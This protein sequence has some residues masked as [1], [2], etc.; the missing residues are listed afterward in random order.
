MVN[1]KFNLRD[2]MKAFG[3]KDFFA[4]S[5]SFV[6][7]NFFRDEKR[8]KITRLIIFF[9]I[10]TIIISYFAIGWGTTKAAPL[11]IGVS[12]IKEGYSEF[13]KI[14]NI[15]GTGISLQKGDLGSWTNDDQAPIDVPDNMYSPEMVY[16][17]SNTIYM[18]T[19]NSSGHFVRYWVE[20]RRW[21]EL[22][23]LPFAN[24]SK[25]TFD[26]SRYFYAIA[27][28]GYNFF[29]YDSYQNVWD[30]MPDPPEELFGGSNIEY[31]GGASSY[32]YAIR[33]GSSG[34]FWRYS[35]GTA[36]WEALTPPAYA[37]TNG[38]AL[39]WDRGDFLYAIRGNYYYNLL[40]YQL[41]TGT[42]VSRGS[43][44][45][46]IYDISRTKMIFLNTNEFYV[47]TYYGWS[48]GKMSKYS[49][50]SNTFSDVNLPMKTYQESMSGVF[51]GTS[52]FYASI[53]GY[54]VNTAQI[55]VMDTG[56]NIWDLGQTNTTTPT[57]Y[58]AWAFDGADNLYAITGYYPIVTYRRNLATGV[59]TYLNP[60]PSGLP[61]A[62]HPTAAYSGGKIYITRGSGYQNFY[63]YDAVANLWQETE[64]AQTPAYVCT[65]S[66]LVDGGDGFLYLSRGCATGTFYRYNISGNTWSTINAI[67]FGMDLGG[68]IAKVGN[69]IYAFSGGDY[70]NNRIAKFDLAAQTWTEENAGAIPIG[71]PY[72]PRI[73]SDGTTNIYILSGPNGTETSSQRRFYQ[74]NTTT[75]AWKRLGDLPDYAR[76][77]SNP[78][79]F[80]RGTD[81][82]AN[83]GTYDTRLWKWSPSAAAFQT[84]GAWY[85]KHYDLTQ[86][87][88]FDQL[89]FDEVG[90]GTATV[91]TRSSSN[92]AAWENWTELSGH[93]VVSNAH[94]YFQF[95][96]VL[97]GDGTATPTLSNFSLSY[98][99]E[100]TPPS[101][102]ST[103]HAYDTSEKQQQLTTGV[104]YPYHHPYFEWSGADD[105]L[106]GS[107]VAGYY[108]YFGTD[109]N[110]DP[111]TA[112]NYQTETLYTAD[113]P[114]TAGDIDYFKIKVKDKLGNISD[115]GPPLFSYRY[116]FISPPGNVTVASNAEFN[117]GTGQGLD[118]T[119]PGGQATLIARPN[120]TWVNS[121]LAKIPQLF[122]GGAATY[123]HD[124]L[125]V[126]T[127]NGTKY[128]YRYDLNANQWVSLADTLVTIPNSYSGSILSYDGDDTI[129]FIAGNLSSSFAKYSISRNVWTNLG[130]L[131][132]PA[133]AE[134]A[135]APISNNKFIV[136]LGSTTFNY[137]YDSQK[138]SFEENVPC[139]GNFT[140]ASN[141]YFDGVDTVYV[142][143]QYNWL[144]KFVISENRWY[145][146]LQAPFY[147]VDN[148]NVAFDGI[149]DDLYFFGMRNAY[150]HFAA[151]Y[152][153]SENRFYEI[154]PP[155]YE[156][157]TTSYVVSDRNR[158]FF[159]FQ[160]AY[161]SSRQ[162]NIFFR[163]DTTNNSYSPNLY[164]PLRAGFFNR[165]TSWYSFGVED[166]FPFYLSDWGSATYDGTDRVY[167]KA[168][169]HLLEYSVSQKKLIRSTRMVYANY[170]SIFYLNGYVYNI[171]SNGTKRFFRY[172]VSTL[173]WEE[174]A[175]APGNVSLYYSENLFADK[176]GRL[177]AA[178]GAGS[179]TIYRYTPGANTW[180][181]LNL[182]PIAIN[183]G[184]TFAYD[185]NHTVY[186]SFSA[187]SSAYYSFDTD[188]GTWSAPLAVINDIKPNYGSYATYRQGKIYMM[189]GANTKKMSIYDIGAN[190]WSAGPDA[191]TEVYRGASF[192][193]INDDYG[194]LAPNGAKAAIWRFNFPSNTHG[195]SAVGVYTS[196]NFLIDGVFS[197]VG[198]EATIDT[199]ANT[200]VEFKTR[201][202]EDG[203]TWSDWQTTTET[204][205]VSNKVYGHIVSP[206]HKNIQVRA[207]LE[208]SDN[209]NRPII[210][211]FKVNYYADTTPPNNPTMVFIYSDSQKTPPALTQ[212]VWYKYDHPLIDWP[213]PGEAGGATDGLIG[214]NIAGYWVYFGFD[215]QAIPETAGQ[216]VTAT[217]YAPTLI[218]PGLY[219]LRIQAVD[220]SGNVAAEVYDAFLY[221]FDNEKPA[222]PAVISVDPSGYTTNNVFTFSWPAANDDYSGIKEYC[223]KTAATS[224]PYQNEQCQ[225]ANQIDSI[226]AA[227]QNG[228]NVIYVRSKDWAE[229]FSESSTQA[230]FYWKDKNLPENLLVTNL[231]YIVNG[232]NQFTF[233]WDV[234]LVYV[235]NVD[236]MSYYFSIN[237]LPS[238]NNTTRVEG[239][240][241]GPFA[242]ATQT[243]TNTFYI[244]ARDEASSLNDINWNNYATIDFSSNLVA[245]GIPVSLVA[246]DVSNRSINR[247]A[248]ALTWGAPSNP[249]SGVDHYVVDRSSD[250]LHYS[251]I[252]TPEDVS[253]VDNTVLENGLYYYRVRASSAVG[254]LGG[255]SSVVQITPIGKYTSAPNVT[256]GPDVTVGVN[257]A[258]I[259]W[260]TDRAAAGYVYYGSDM[261]TLIDSSGS[262][263]PETN[264]SV[265]IRG[266]N[267]NSVYYYQIQNFD[268]GR[269]YSL[270]QAL[271]TIRTFRTK[272][273]AVIQDVTVSEVKL[274][275]AKISWTTPS[276]TTFKLQYGKTTSYGLNKT[277]NAT[278]ETQS[279]E[280][281]DLENT[282]SYHFKITSTT[283]DG[284]EI[285]SDDYQ[286]S[287]LAY[288]V[289]TDIKFQPVE[290]SSNSVEVTW[291][292]NVK[293]TSIV[294]YQLGGTIKEEQAPASG[295][296]L[297][298]SVTLTKLADSAD[299]LV[300]VKGVDEYGNNA[301]GATQHWKTGV[302]TRQPKVSNIKTESILSAD[303]SRAQIVVSWETDEPTTSEVEYGLNKKYDSKS[304]KDTNL[305]NRHV[306]VI[307]NLKV[308]QIYHVRPNSEDKSG[309]KNFGE[310]NIVVIG[311]KDTN[312]IQIVL[313]FIRNVFGWIKIGR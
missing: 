58:T 229:N 135:M 242:A 45:P 269:E 203:V 277:G 183:D 302:D 309:N 69:Y 184:Y 16:G 148:Q 233:T 155:P 306:V 208:S 163:Y 303:E 301:I 227:Y 248:V 64:L 109:S 133:G 159:I 75:K 157:N 34:Y 210:Y 252:G 151:R 110:A 182:A 176:E 153:I 225:V 188:N 220:A 62:S 102:P 77:T 87:S 89:S 78:Y 127:G 251:Q 219:Y 200:S 195:N 85:S 112:G 44:Y 308:A 185:G 29:R 285:S 190:T 32:I 241:V 191:P 226:S 80:V 116:W 164:T 41:S 43:F 88:D 228:A 146:L 174:L 47:M 42:W 145:T 40:R 143:T 275:S 310:D 76:G 194:L 197:W 237:A 259:T 9:L 206:I 22:A 216:Y 117:E 231:D 198:V 3:Q 30:K 217:E 253:F 13:N 70:G 48:S 239:L 223:F 63:L 209:F 7:R 126:V 179:K 213:N 292:T 189:K 38:S 222:R 243:G 202:T 181:T 234:P 25:L 246:S 11:V 230:T 46:K 162:D 66:T 201:T 39:M 14:D 156:L 37:F 131:P 119:D 149:G 300:T 281:T 136:S 236:K 166:G 120:G 278:S 134:T 304:T 93:N 177:Y 296:T 74:F 103:L 55:R 267:P 2:E 4:K 12:D 65:G 289:I 273:A 33:G 165:S 67:P 81:V 224:G 260:T 105:G 175:N 298:H 256:K 172:N 160:N 54:D 170:G 101:L 263:N 132:G 218:D 238:V 154:A 167:I 312:I 68:S 98:S 50:L 56:T 17:P 90:V 214:S 100:T 130:V 173:E 24:F 95:K 247:W 192:L 83:K 262:I 79:L 20:E 245:P 142:I 108:V 52:K 111:A 150:G 61:I 27:N 211:D 122:K 138:D 207:F 10:I 255:Y 187:S 71:Y 169:S 96:V 28:T 141:F 60:A 107:G 290:G 144:R 283:V 178:V 270:D 266:L 59:E 240:S 72:G 261:G 286:F 129:Y 196:K 294:A 268:E 115:S 161:D 5:S 123:A 258:T 313:K 19:D 97:H 297:E 57:P 6:L 274:T 171:I 128:F 212:N 139:P 104:T 106:N 249:G 264:H 232:P 36:Q 86:A 82:Y 299:Y 271:S 291:K 15:A 180:E 53:G 186:F 307:S 205:R 91:S 73:A 199:P 158:Y 26:G 311:K 35:I 92:L 124:N 31:V 49:A 276:V 204:K 137:I 8:K 84:D 21:E 114:M 147:F 244:V 287:T 235:G 99:Q 113:L 121:D 125:Y 305:T 257:R 250:K 168:Y 295:Y 272:Q 280:L 118:M 51:D 254:D 193:K 1:R 140:T 284:D 94:R 23:P 282:T 265:M 18:L 288:P 279:V 152:S 221:K 215:A 293:T